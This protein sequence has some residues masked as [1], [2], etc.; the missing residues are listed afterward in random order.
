MEELVRKLSL[1][2]TEES[3]QETPREGSEVMEFIGD[4]GV[5]RLEIDNPLFENR[6]SSPLL[7]PDLSVPPLF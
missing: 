5:N 7:I 4:L 3:W 1:K 6:S 2:G